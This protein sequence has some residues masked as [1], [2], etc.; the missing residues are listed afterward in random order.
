MIKSSLIIAAAVVPQ[1]LSA[2]ADIQLWG[3]TRTKTA[4]ND[5]SQSPTSTCNKEN[6]NNWTDTTANGGH[7]ETWYC[8]GVTGVFNSEL[9]PD[10]YWIITDKDGGPFG[11]LVTS[12][13]KCY[14]GAT[15]IESHG[16]DFK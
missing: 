5:A 7:M 15:R 9:S 4:S 8:R 2:V 12:H 6:F 11:E 3:S 1:A 16:W 13:D 14:Y 10:G